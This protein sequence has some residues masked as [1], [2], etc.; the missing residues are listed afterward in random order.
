MSSI[1]A[2]VR[3]WVILIVCIAVSV[4]A[5]VCLKLGVQQ[6]RG[7]RLGAEPLGPALLRLAA[8]GWLWLGIALY[9]SGTLLWLAVLSEFPMNEAIL[10]FSSNTI[11]MLLFSVTLFGERITPAR[12]VGVALVLTGLYLVK[13]TS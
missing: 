2:N 8:A 11:V 12:M 3:P 13:R 9:G 10:Y 4:S 6:A 7:I 5:Q 1:P